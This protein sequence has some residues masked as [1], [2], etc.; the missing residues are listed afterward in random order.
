V[1]ILAQTELRGPFFLPRAERAPGSA[2]TPAPWG[3]GGWPEWA[4]ILDAGQGWAF[5][6]RGDEPLRIGIGAG[7]VFDL[8]GIYAARDASGANLF[9][10]LGRR[11]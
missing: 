3:G 8:F 9:V 2:A 11:F 10:R 4:L 1:T 6:D 5:D 7:I